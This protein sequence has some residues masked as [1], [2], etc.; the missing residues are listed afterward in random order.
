VATNAPKK[1]ALRDDSSDSSDS[2][3]YD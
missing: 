2:E 1:Q 3:D